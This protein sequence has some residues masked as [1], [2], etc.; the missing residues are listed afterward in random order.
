MESLG[1]YGKFV[2]L[3]LFVGMSKDDLED[4]IAKT[5]FDFFKVEAGR[6]IVK[7]GVRSGQLLLLIDGE[8]CVR[9]S[10]DDH[11]YSVEEFA[12]A[13]W[14]IQPEHTFGLTQ[15]YTCSVTALTTCNLVCIDKKE[16]LRLSNNSLIFRL[17][18]LN[19]LSTALQKRYQMAWKSVPDT[20][21][22]R[23]VRFF[24]DHC[25]HPA[26][27]KVFHIKR[28]RLAAEVN[29]NR[30]RVSA[31]LH[32]MNVQGK[33]FLHRGCIEIPSLERLINH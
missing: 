25:A 21:E 28:K 23:I 17:N 1:L 8:V 27:H 11:G 3:P 5:K 13:S 33:L 14:V 15:R 29:D 32:T 26:G 12:K 4:I 9:T 6:T 18:L 7:E 31:V 30:E 24:I 10:A 16:T 19:I 20:L 22:L 2:T